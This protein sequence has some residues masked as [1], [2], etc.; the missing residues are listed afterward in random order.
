MVIKSNPSIIF[1]RV[2]KMLAF[3]KIGQSAY[4][5]LRNVGGAAVNCG[6]KTIQGNNSFNV[7]VKELEIPKL[8]IPC[9]NRPT[10]HKNS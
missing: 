8:D 6:N 2:I 3:S 10:F 1:I 5:L 9:E 4:F 7:K